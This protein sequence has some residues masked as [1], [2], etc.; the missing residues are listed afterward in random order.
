MSIKV[1]D[2]LLLL[3][4]EFGLATLAQRGSCPGVCMNC[5]H[6]QDYCDPTLANGYCD[7]CSK[8]KVRSWA[9][10]AGVL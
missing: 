8:P 5:T 7:S 1:R 9:V 4:G 2:A 3:Q 6:I 10:L